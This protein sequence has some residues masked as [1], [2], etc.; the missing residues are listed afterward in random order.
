M[1]IFLNLMGAT[2]FFYKEMLTS[3]ISFSS[4]NT[5]SFNLLLKAALLRLK[6]MSFYNFFFVA[7]GISLE[8]SHKLP[9]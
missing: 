4:K 1:E 9:N 6:I 5:F 3:L 8:T 7:N 2:D